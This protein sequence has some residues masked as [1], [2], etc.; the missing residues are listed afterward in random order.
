M[1]AHLRSSRSLLH[2][3]S[4]RSARRCSSTEREIASPLLE[5]ICRT[6]SRSS[7]SPIRRSGAMRNAARDWP[8]ML[9]RSTRHHERNGS[10]ELIAL[11]SSDCDSCGESTALKL[12]AIAFAV[13][14]VQRL[15]VN[16]RS[17]RISLS[18]MTTSGVSTVTLMVSKSCQFIC[19][20]SLACVHQTS[21]CRT[22]SGSGLRAACCASAEPVVG[23]PT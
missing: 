11:S 14:A 15:S 19:A 3:C 1:P 20:S 22:S 18:V 21:S 16:E 13:A 7:R 10:P 8:T 9:S 6:A 12:V 5:R 23:M 2:T 17:K 4:M